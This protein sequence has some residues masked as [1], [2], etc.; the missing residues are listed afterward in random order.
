METI[1]FDNATQVVRI[2]QSLK[3]NWRELDVVL[4]V[5]KKTL[6]KLEYE[7]FVFDHG[8]LNTIARVLSQ[9]PHAL[10][11][12]SKLAEIADTHFV[13]AYVKK[14]REQGMDIRSSLEDDD[15]YFWVVVDD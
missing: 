2:L 12:G 7:P 11:P 14:L 13:N 8:K 6:A 10:W 15:Q 9:E 3:P 1:K 5:G 4:Q